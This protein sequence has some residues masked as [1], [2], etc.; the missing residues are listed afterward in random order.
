MPRRREQETQEVDGDFVFRSR[1]RAQ[2]PEALVR[3]AERAHVIGNAFQR[4]FHR[5]KKEPAEFAAD[6]FAA[7]IGRHTARLGF[8][9]VAVRSHIIEI[10]DIEE[11]H[12]FIRSALILERDRRFVETREVIVIRSRCVG[13]SQQPVK[14]FHHLF[15]A[16]RRRS[17]GLRVVEVLI[18]DFIEVISIFI[19]GVNRGIVRAVLPRRVDIGNVTELALGGMHVAREIAE[20]LIE[21]HIDHAGK[22]IETVFAARLRTA[23]KRKRSFEIEFGF[24]LRRFQGVHHPVPTD[25]ACVDRAVRADGVVP[26]HH[27]FHRGFVIKRHRIV[28]GIAQPRHGKRRTRLHRTVSVGFQGVEPSAV[29]LDEGILFFE[30][31]RQIDDFIG[32][33]IFG[34]Y[35]G[36]GDRGIADILNGVAQILVIRVGIGVVAHA[37]RNV[38]S[39]FVL[40]VLVRIG[41]ALERALLDDVHRSIKINGCRDAL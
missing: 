24:F 38:V 16:C 10:F 32:A 14:I 39:F 1:T 41:D 2:N 31:S 30:I 12:V 13:I 3:P 25:L 36:I 20:I 21:I 17:V 11:F 7:R 34:Q 22:H 40:I 35:R 33:V 26:F 8:E 9:G 27:R 15:I 29:P 19:G 18:D 37:H 5:G 28:G 4:R 6:D 23:R